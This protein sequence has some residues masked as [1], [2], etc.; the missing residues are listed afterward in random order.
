MTT[1]VD[2]YIFGLT[3]AQYTAKNVPVFVPVFLYAV[4]TRHSQIKRMI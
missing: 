3:N 2:M 1:K 4:T